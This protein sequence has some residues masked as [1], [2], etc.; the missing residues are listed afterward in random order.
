MIELVLRLGLSL[1][2]VLGLFWAIARTGSKRMGGSRSLMK[3]RSRQSLSRSSSVAVVEV[4][5]RVLVVGVSD[6]GVALLTELDPAEVAET[7]PAAQAV[8][9]TAPGRRAAR[10]PLAAR[11]LRLRPAMRS[12]GG[13]RRAGVPV[14]SPDRELVETEAPA[15]PAAPLPDFATVLAAAQAEQPPVRPVAPAPAPTPPATLPDRLVAAL[16]AALVVAAEAELAAVRPATH[17]ATQVAP[18]PDSS[19]LAGSV[20]APGTWKSAWAALSSR[21]ARPVASQG[22]S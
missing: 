8:A 13:K 10:T 6:G 1:G 11:P 17:V 5:S 7:A 3:V 16:P 15:V 21:S 4:G 19:P 9:S 22:R 14:T 12:T 18:A 2:I 20:L